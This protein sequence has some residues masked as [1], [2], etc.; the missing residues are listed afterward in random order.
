MTVIYKTID[1]KHKF[2]Q[3]NDLHTLTLSQLLLYFYITC[4]KMNQSYN[5]LSTMVWHKQE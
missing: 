3:K 1:L 5:Y 2:H 4:H